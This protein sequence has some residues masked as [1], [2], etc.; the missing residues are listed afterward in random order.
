MQNLLSAWKEFKK[1]KMNKSEVQNFAFNL[2][3]NLFNIHDKLKT[4]SYKPSK[5]DFF[6]VRDPKLRPIHK[7]TVRDRVIFQAVF[8]ILYHVFDPVFIYDS[9]SCRLGK[10]THAGTKRLEKFARKASKNYRQDCLVLKCDIK[11]FFYS[12]DHDIF[13]RLIGKKIRDSKLFNLIE[14]IIGSFQVQPGKGLPLGNVT[15]QLFTN[16]YLHELDTF[17]KHKL[18]EK[19]YIRYCDDF[20]II[21]KD[22][23]HLKSLIPKLNIFLREKLK[24]NLHTRK[25]EIRKLNQGVDFLGYVVLPHRTVLRTKTKKR[26]FKKVKQKVVDCNSGVINDFELNQSLQSYLGMLEHCA[27]YKI[28]TKL[29]NEVWLDKEVKLC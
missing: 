2:E 29:E 6:F 11:Q 3:N 24:L 8:R 19:Y 26:M 14:K 22:Y 25:T 13:M 20:V 1:G 5:Y 27:G 16:I 23:S 9:Y 12:V 18:K 17:V 10:G 28:K 15:S 7:A 21:G 4:E